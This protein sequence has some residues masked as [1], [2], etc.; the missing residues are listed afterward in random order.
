MDWIAE[1]SRDFVDAK[2]SSCNTA[3][4][5]TLIDPITWPLGESLL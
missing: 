1:V 2:N 3:A 5:L 4:D